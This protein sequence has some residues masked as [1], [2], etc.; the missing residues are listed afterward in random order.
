MLEVLPAPG[1]QVVMS[2]M[3][4]LVTPVSTHFHPATCVPCCG[5]EPPQDMNLSLP[6]CKPDQDC[7]EVCSGKETQQWTQGPADGSGY[8]MMHSVGRPGYCLA[9]GDPVQQPLDPWCTKNNNSESSTQRRRCNADS[10]TATLFLDPDGQLASR[11]VRPI[12]CS[13]AEQH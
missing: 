10:L 9:S 3:P 1:N 12:V 11:R 13:V 2:G 8:T 4:C 6:G 5:P 7:A